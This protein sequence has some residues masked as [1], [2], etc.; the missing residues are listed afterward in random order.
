MTTNVI[1]K[2]GGETHLLPIKLGGRRTIMKF[3]V[4]GKE[5]NS[6]PMDF[7]TVCTLEDMGIGLNDYGRKGTNL[8]RA[9]FS[10]CANLSVTE[11]GKE[12]EQHV[13]S[14]GTLDE[15]QKVFE[16]EAEN[17][18]FFRALNKTEETETT[19]KKSKEGK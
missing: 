1:H 10:I 14:G 9:Y 18:D 16:N 17:S 5:Y 8:M 11:A 15:F 2:G 12:I 13:I 4:N 19:E 6:V 3:V 7:N